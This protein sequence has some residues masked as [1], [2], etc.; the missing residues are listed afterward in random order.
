M[1]SAWEMVRIDRIADFAPVP[2]GSWSKPIYVGFA[3]PERVLEGAIDR[4]A[5]TP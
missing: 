2:A 5:D 1:I 3:S 4:S